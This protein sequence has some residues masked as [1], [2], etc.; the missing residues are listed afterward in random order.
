MTFELGEG[1]IVKGRDHRF[2]FSKPF[3]YFYAG[4]D[5]PMPQL[6]NLGPSFPS[7]KVVLFKF[8]IICLLQRNFIYL[9]IFL[10]VCSYAM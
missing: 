9:F 1:M 6:F 2:C 4:G 10:F 8:Y 5:A 3:S 7:L